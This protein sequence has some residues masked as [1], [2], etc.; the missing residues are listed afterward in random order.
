M[1]GIEVGLSPGDRRF[2]PGVSGHGR[3]V[4]FQGR[5]RA[6]PVIRGCCQVAPE[7]KGAGIVAVV[8][9]YKVVPRDAHCAVPDEKRFDAAGKGGTAIGSVRSVADPNADGAVVFGGS[10]KVRSVF[11]VN[12]EFG[13]VTVGKVVVLGVEQAYLTVVGVRSGEQ[14]EFFVRN[15]KDK[16]AVLRSRIRRGETFA[17]GTFPS[18][19]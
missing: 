8:L 3:A 13:V 15:E 10:G 18:V 2:Y 12:F 7:G 5:E 6:S 9:E 4:G 16:V 17:G 11:Q 14:V 1:I 19:V